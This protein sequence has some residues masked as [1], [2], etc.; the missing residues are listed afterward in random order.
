MPINERGEFVRDGEAPK[1]EGDPERGEAIRKD[2]KLADRQEEEPDAG[3]VSEDKK[4]AMRR[5]L[6]GE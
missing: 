1:K 6:L 5:K 2:Q 4:A 3:P